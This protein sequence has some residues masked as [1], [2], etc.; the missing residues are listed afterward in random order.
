MR[1][2]APVLSISLTLLKLNMKFTLPS[3]KSPQKIDQNG[4][5]VGIGYPVFA[6]N[7]IHVR[8]DKPLDE[9]IMEM[10]GA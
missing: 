5:L 2:F 8:F 1:I 10:E 3:A 6:D 7:S 4:T 9:A